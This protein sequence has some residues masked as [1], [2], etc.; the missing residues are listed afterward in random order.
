MF[1]LEQAKYQN[2][3]VQPNEINGLKSEKA[4]YLIKT[5]TSLNLV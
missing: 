3:S 1:K 5:Y 4:P 2:I